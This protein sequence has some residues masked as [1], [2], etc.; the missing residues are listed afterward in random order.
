MTAIRPSSQISNAHWLESLSPEDRELVR[1][2]PREQREYLD[3]WAT[4]S[5]DK[6]EPA[7]PRPRKRNPITEALWLVGGLSGCFAWFA[8][9]NSKALSIPYMEAVALTFANA[10][11]DLPVLAGAV[12]AVPVLRAINNR[13]PERQTGGPD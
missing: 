3:R 9:I 2:L 13:I 6:P 5:I 10:Q 12:A 1:S 8:Q 4:E 11:G 7:T